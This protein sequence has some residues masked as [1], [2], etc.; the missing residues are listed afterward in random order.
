VT[1]IADE[2]LPFGGTWTWELE[3]N[4][5]GTRLSITAD[6]FVRPALFRVMARFVFGYHATMNA[7]LEPCAASSARRSSP[8]TR[9]PERKPRASYFTR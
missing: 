2:R 4:D 8:S 9:P 7:Y 3:P 6:G 1:R 5:G